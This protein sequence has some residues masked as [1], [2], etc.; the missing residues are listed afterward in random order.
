MQSLFNKVMQLSCNVLR[1]YKQFEI[2]NNIYAHHTFIRETALHDRIIRKR[3][4]I[5]PVI[6]YVIHIFPRIVTTC[7]RNQLEQISRNMCNITFVIQ[8]PRD[9]SYVFTM[10]SK[11]IFQKIY[12]Y[13]INC[14]IIKLKNTFRHQ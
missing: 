9:S 5:I 6:C 7:V 11:A 3:V 10:L 13:I 1:F 12:R 14:F 2:Y 4:N 8:L